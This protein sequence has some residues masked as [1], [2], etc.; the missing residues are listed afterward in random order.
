MLFADGRLRAAGTVEG[1]L[2]ELLDATA[3]VVREITPAIAAMAAHV[4]SGFP[5][6]P[7]DRLIAATAK[8][9]GATL[10]T[11]DQRIAESGYVR[12]LW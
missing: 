8:A 6:D 11:A 5:R 4:P 7:A 1:A 9:E 12:T 10:V 3:V 2:G